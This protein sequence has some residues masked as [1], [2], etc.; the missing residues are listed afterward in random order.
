MSGKQASAC[1]LR[2]LG[3]Q[4]WEF[5][6]RMASNAAKRK[7]DGQPVSWEQMIA[8]IPLIVCRSPAAHRYR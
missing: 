4:L 7:H 2:S 5:D 1:N 6:S 8:Q 3:H